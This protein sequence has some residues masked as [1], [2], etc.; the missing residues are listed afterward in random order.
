M[1]K[2]G[3]RFLLEPIELA[4]LGTPE[5]FTDEQLMIARMTEDFVKGRVWPVMDELEANP[6]SHTVG[7]LKDA[8][9]LGL[10]GAD[11][12][13]AYGGVG[14]DKIS[15]TL[16]TEKLA[17]GRSF[18]LSHGAHVGIGTLPI[19][20]FG[21][22]AQKQT[23]LPALATGEK[24]AAYALTE[25]SSGSDAL[26]AKT[27]AKLTEDGQHYVLNGE[28]QWIT[29]AG[30]ADVFI[31]YAKV[32]GKHFSA[33]IVERNFAG[34]STGVEE[35]KMGIKGSSTRTLILDN[36]KVPVA[37]L[38]GEIGKG[39]LI[40]FNILNMGRFKLAAGTVG[41]AKRAIELSATYANT[42]KQFGQPI[43]RFGLIQQ[44]LADMA[45]QTFALESVVY[46]IAGL[47]E[48]GLAGS[49]QADG[50]TVAKQIGDYA[51]E[52]SIAKVLGSEILDFVVDEGVQIHGGYGYMH[53]YEIEQLYRDSR[54]NRIFEGTNEINRLLIPGTLLRKALKGEL[55]LMDVFTKL[56]KQLIAY[57][58][59][60]NSAE[61]LAEAGRLTENIKQIF[62]LTAGVAVD[63]YGQQLSDQ[64]EIMQALADIIIQLFAA[65]S[66]VCRAQKHLQSQGADKAA[67]A[68]DYATVYTHQAIK[69]ITHSAEQALAH[70]ATGDTLRTQ[71]AILQKL[72]RHEAI[73][74]IRY[75]QRIAKRVLEAEKY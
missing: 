64:Q 34:I 70:L 49:E 24:L 9:E 67:L 60:T 52:C 68:S 27:T 75:K 65:E 72:T 18:A 66:A 8:G 63:K 43:A 22:E 53:E 58:P 6:L 15:A 10:L 59:P 54:I 3:G 35:K 4:S 7:L 37:N 69:H 55:P 38:L 21:S 26:G 29:N 5:E 31:V 73:D 39:H 46:R 32:D 17:L 48:A 11:V 42:R 56:T 2:R 20:F 12:P 19:V 62:L 33:F 57:V 41:T 30:F 61:P 51:I 25:P 23:Y 45:I 36:V 40:A 47:F 28:K 1:E 14:L 16:I 71:L 13:E 74:L 50:A 44:K